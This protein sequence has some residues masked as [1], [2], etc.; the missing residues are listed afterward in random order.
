MI[1]SFDSRIENWV[2]EIIYGSNIFIID[3]K[4]EDI[5]DYVNNIMV[6]FFKSPYLPPSV[7]F[8]TTPL[9]EDITEWRD[10]QEAY[11]KYL[12]NFELPDGSYSY[13]NLYIMP[14]LISDWFAM[15]RPSG[16]N[17]DIYFS[18]DIGSARKLIKAHSLM[19]NMELDSVTVSGRFEEYRQVLIHANKMAFMDAL[20]SFVSFRELNTITP[21]E[22]EILK[23]E[24]QKV[25]II[26]DRNTLELIKY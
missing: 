23:E 24:A 21:R 2:Y 18:R 26:R 12:G 14:F 8:F 6:G 20:I 15:F 3:S 13:P 16:I 4:P 9:L 25:G 10:A 1:I 17:S 22:K 19:F 7:N 5:R 11:A